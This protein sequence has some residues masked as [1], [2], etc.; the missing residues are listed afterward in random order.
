MNTLDIIIISILIFFIV[1]G[2]F[3]GFIKELASIIGILGGLYSAYVYH[4]P[5][6]NQISKWVSSNYL[7]ILSFLLIFIIVFVL[8]NLIGTIIRHILKALLIIWVDRIF[9]VAIGAIKGI[10]ILSVLLIILAVLLPRSSTFVKNSLIS[11]YMLMV[12][13]EVVKV[14]PNDL[15]KNFDAKMRAFLMRKKEYLEK[16]T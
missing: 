5:L 16:K 4:I 11:H 3:R 9:G 15:K 12:S 13:N 2:F 14:I 7:N 10:L 6:S 1:R 8:I